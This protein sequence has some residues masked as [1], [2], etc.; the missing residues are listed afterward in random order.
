MKF[1]WKLY[2]TI[3]LMVVTCF[4]VGGYL[5]IETGFKSSLQR[6]IEMAYQENDILFSSFM[7]DLLTPVD[8]FVNYENSKKEKFSV[9]QN[10]AATLRVQT[11]NG[12][13]SFCLRDNTGKMIYQN[14]GF[15]DDIS[16]IK[17]IKSGNRGYKI[18]ENK[19]KYKIH[20]LRKLEMAI[21]DV[22]IYLE[23]SRDISSLFKGRKEQYQTFMYCI[24]LLSLVGAI[25]I[26]IV[27]RWLVKPIEKLSQAT[28]QITAEG[29]GTEI[30]VS[31]DDEIGQLTKDFNTMTK[32]LMVSMDKL[33]EALNRQE[34]FVGN[35]AHELKTPL[36]SM[37]GYGDM[38]RSKKLSEEQIISY[39][40]LIVQEG[41]RLEV[42]SMKLMELIVLKKQNFEM[43]KINTIEFFDEIKAVVAP[44][45]KDSK[46]EFKVLVED[47]EILIEP[48][49]MKTVCL[50]LLD[51]ARKA[52]I[53]NGVIELIGVK[54]NDCYCIKVKD[55]GC[56]IDAKEI[57]KIKEEFYMVDK[58]RSRSVGGAGLGLAI[59]DQI[60]KLHHGEMKFESIK[61]QG[62]VVTVLLKGGE[63]FEEN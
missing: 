47:I 39:A 15:L 5:L 45:M 62:T 44:I 4:S 55:N 30:K 35:F 17:E 3:M 48:D 1:F 38:L 20:T 24:G 61:N 31:S 14:G 53:N 32:R 51:N 37:I 33:Q 49:L 11:F 40:N 7:N 23:N 50:N 6:E 21:D 41:K 19:S 9:I 10:S 36:T 16:M 25:V 60:V 18:T 57:G 43:V 34:I 59:C 52:I 27:T 2:L 13:I 26:F 28:K 56:G 46:I 54:S 58:S 63:I 42:M 22:D 8:G 12:G 29:L